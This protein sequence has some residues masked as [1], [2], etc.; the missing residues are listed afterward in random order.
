[1]LKDERIGKVDIRSDYIEEPAKRDWLFK[2]SSYMIVLRAESMLYRNAREDVAIS[3]L[4]EISHEG[5]IIQKMIS[6]C[7]GIASFLRSGPLP[8]YCGSLWS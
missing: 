7:Y 6:L 8:R 5:K 1:V 2:R 4:F 3:P